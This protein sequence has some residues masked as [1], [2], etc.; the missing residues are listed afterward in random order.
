MVDTC[1]TEGFH[2]VA[3]YPS[4]AAKANIVMAITALH[5]QN[6]SSWPASTQDFDWFIYKC[7]RCWLLYNTLSFANFSLQRKIPLVLTTDQ[8]H[9]FA[10]CVCFT[11]LA[12]SVR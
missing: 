4:R 9:T 6:L 1:S 2:T 3:L 11:G 12:C 5:N 10:R 8:I 7:L